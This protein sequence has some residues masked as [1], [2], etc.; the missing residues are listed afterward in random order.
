MMI[1]LIKVGIEKILM[2]LPK[3]NGGKFLS[4]KL[5]KALSMINKNDFLILFPA[6]RMVFQI[7][8]YLFQIFELKW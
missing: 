5:K 7:K 1:N 6:K 4:F 2:M 8:N 3:F